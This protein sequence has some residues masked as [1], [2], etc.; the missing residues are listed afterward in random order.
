VVAEG[1][2]TALREEHGTDAT[3]EWTETDGTSHQER[4]ATPTR[5]VAEL[6]HRFDGE[7]PGLRITR[8]TLEDVY[9]RLAGQENA[10]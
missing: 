6:M 9:L 10:R 1:T 4:T 2:P 7:I 3:V 8:P 5:T